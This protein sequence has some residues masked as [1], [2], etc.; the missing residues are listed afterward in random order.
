MANKP[1]QV[2]V[3]MCG[4]GPERL[5]LPAST[6]LGGQQPLHCLHPCGACGDVHGPWLLCRVSLPDPGEEGEWLACWRHPPRVHP[7]G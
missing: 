5:P 6:S 2:A 4:E 1:I 3:K 7:T